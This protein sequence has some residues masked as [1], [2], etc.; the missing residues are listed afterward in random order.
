MLQSLGKPVA[1]LYTLHN[2]N[3]TF[4]FFVA[5][6]KPV[7][8]FGREPVSKPNILKIY[9]PGVYRTVWYIVRSIQHVTVTEETRS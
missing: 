5:N 6:Q 4:R 8:N 3:D 1:I 2:N 7:Y 9:L